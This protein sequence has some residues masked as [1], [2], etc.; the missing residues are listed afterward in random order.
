MA[1][2]RLIDE[3]NTQDALALLKVTVEALERHGVRYYLD[4]GTLIG[5]VREKGFIPWDDDVDISI[6]NEEDYQNIPGILKEIRAQYKYRTYVFSFKSSRMKF[7]RRGEAV[8]TDDLFFTDKN[9]LQM[10]KLRNNKFWRF[11]R[12]NTC[13]DIFFKYQYNGHKY[14]LAYGKVNSVPTEFLNDQDLVKIKFYDL[15]CYIPM[16]YDEY[17]TYK[18]GN[19]RVPNNNWTHDKDDFSINTP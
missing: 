15:E 4:F 11:G 5:A 9:S 13:L 8:R 6:A 17:L 10:A 14:W 12:G 3:K 1:D 19:W 16:N 18:Y 7:T 2:R